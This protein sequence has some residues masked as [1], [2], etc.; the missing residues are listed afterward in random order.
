MIVESLEQRL[1]LAGN[2]KVRADDGILFIQGDRAGNDIE[3][4]PGDSNGEI[5]L[6]GNRL[7]GSPT[8]I[9]GKSSL[10]VRSDSIRILLGMG[11]DVV[12]V[13]DVQ[14]RDDLLIRNKAGHDQIRLINS[15]MRS[16]SLIRTGRCEYRSG[17]R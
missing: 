7:G 16:V 9:N 1:L 15:S 11:D 6:S 14:F 10:T 12:E 3:I 13:R 4:T 8:T 5:R 17:Q 2:V